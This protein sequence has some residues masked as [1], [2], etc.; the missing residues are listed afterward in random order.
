MSSPTGPFV[1]EALGAVRELCESIA[2]RRGLELVETKLGREGKRLMLRVT[3]DR[4]EGGITLD[5]VAEV[6]EE[7][8]HALDEEDP[9]DAPYTLEVSSPGI[10]RPLVR[11]SDYVRFA[12]H[13]VKVRCLEAVEGRRTFQGVIRSTS[14]ATFVLE[15][16]GPEVVEIPYATVASAKLVVNW[17]EELRRRGAQAEAE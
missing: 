5:E 3:M 7:I 14:K 2:D 1:P 6:S 16:P 13:E 10:E 15:L 11:P 12:G 4:P 8:S 9:I 17:E